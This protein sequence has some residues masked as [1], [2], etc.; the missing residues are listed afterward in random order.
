MVL[1]QLKA[2][3]IVHQNSTGGENHMDT[4]AKAQDGILGVLP[5]SGNNG[6]C[7]SELKGH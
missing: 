3:G 7:T 4:E 6:N 1:A 5:Y 2:M